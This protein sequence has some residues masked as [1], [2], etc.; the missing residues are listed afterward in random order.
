LLVPRGY[1]I[2]LAMHLLLPKSCSYALANG[3]KRQL[4]N[5]EADIEITIDKCRVSRP[6]WEMPCLCTA[7]DNK[8]EIEQLSK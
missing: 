5:W 3:W 6:S 8:I 7:L 4:P 1:E 2:L